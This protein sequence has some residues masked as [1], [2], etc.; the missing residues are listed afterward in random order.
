[1]GADGFSKRKTRG[2]AGQLCRTAQK[3]AAQAACAA[4]L[5]L[6]VLVWAACGG[7]LALPCA[8]AA[9]LCLLHYRRMAYERFGGITGD[10]AGWFV[11]LTEAADIAVIILGGKLL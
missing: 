11:Q 3:R 5:L 6:C 1:M 2:H 4:Y 7:W 10:L 9:A 8:A